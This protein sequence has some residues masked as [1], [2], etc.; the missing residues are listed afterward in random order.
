DRLDN[1]AGENA[2]E[3][4]AKLLKLTPK[5]PIRYAALGVGGRIRLFQNYTSNHEAIKTAVRVIT[6][7]GKK[8]DPRDMDVDAEK[9]LID[10]AQSGTDASG[11]AASAQDRELAKVML[12]ALRDGQRCIQDQHASPVF[13]GLLA[14]ARSEREMPGRKVIIYF[15]EGQPSGSNAVDM[16]RMIVGAANRA[17]VTIYV[18][19]SN[20]L[21]PV[22]MQGLQVA[23]AITNMSAPAA[24]GPSNPIPPGM[25][26]QIGEQMGRIELDGM[27]G[28]RS[29]LAMLASGTGGK[30]IGAAEGLKKSVQRMF[31]DMTSYYQIT[32]VPPE[33]DYDGSFRP[34]TI[35]PLRRGLKITARSGYF[36]TPPSTGSGVR[37]FEA[38]LL[39]VLEKPNLPID[40]D[41]RSEVLRLG[42]LADGDENSLAVEVPMNDIEFNQDA[43]TA[44]YS[45]HIS[46]VSQIKTESGTLVQHFS[47][48]IPRHGDL[49]F[50]ERARSETITIQRHFTAPPGDYILETAV[51]DRNSGKAGG[52]RS[53]FHVAKASDGPSL[54]DI[55]FVRRQ[56]PLNA[57]IDGDEPLRYEDS[58][59]LPNLSGAVPAGEKSLSFFFLIHPA[60]NMPAKNAAERPRVEVELRRDGRRITRQPLE[61]H[62][63]GKGPI[64]Y[65]LSLRSTALPAGK[66]EL[67]SILTEGEDTAERKIEFVVAGSETAAKDADAKTDA[68][69]VQPKAEA[70]IFT[71]ADDLRAPAE[72]QIAELLSRAQQKAGTY[73]QSLPNFICIERT[74][75][76]VDPSGLG[77]WHHKDNIAELLRYNDRQER[78]VTLEV[79]GRKSSLEREDFKG[80]LSYGEFGGMFEAIFRPEAKA[81]FHWKQTDMLGNAT[82]QVFSYNVTR[83]TSDFTIRDDSGVAGK[84][85]FHG[86]LYIDETTNEIR[87]ITMDAVEVPENFVIRTASFAV[88]YDYV[89]IGGHDYLMPVSGSMT[90][91]KGKR[92]VVLN[93]IE[94]RDYRKYGAESSLR[95]E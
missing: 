77:R 78:R 24:P 42:Q 93:E 54:S 20:A 79:N 89:D 10:I 12:T 59:L 47:E 55:V 62:N 67:A 60:K 64:P 57:E 25:V 31:E 23:L 66:Y 76:S 17:G 63:R 32:Y 13:G 19:D 56:V 87:R 39:K 1:S 5:A 40:I 53:K 81:A 52:I 37:P 35:S 7:A 50:L 68:R 80:T 8:G 43:N 51:M 92:G 29:P 26:T 22:V 6:G 4:T 73:V 27:A 95:Y 30:Y 82:V 88:D 18:I 28:L 91:G 16:M 65:L 94:F 15:S 72:A 21:D 83:D 71:E 9:G 85:A 61:L 3:I 74:E 46:V 41:L 33:H 34:V 58:K 48:D 2:R 11:K 44:R 36:A 45:A 14:L 84:V 70:L 38:P 90:V 69:A 75:R 49:E 86:L